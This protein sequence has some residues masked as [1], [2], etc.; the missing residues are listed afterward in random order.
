[1]KISG[2]TAQFRSSSNEQRHEFTMGANVQKIFSVLTNMYSDAPLAVFREYFCNAIDANRMQENQSGVKPRPVE[3]TIPGDGRSDLVIRDY[4]VGMDEAFVTKVFNS[5][6]TSEKDNS[7]DNIGGFGI[8]SKSALAYTSSF[9]VTTYS[10]TEVSVYSVYQEDGNQPVLQKLFS[11]DSNEPRGVSISVPVK[12]GDHHSFISAA[13][14][15]LRWFDRGSDYELKGYNLGSSSFDKPECAYTDDDCYIVDSHVNDLN[16]GPHI[17]CGSVLYSATSLDLTGISSLA[18][19]YFLQKANTTWN[20]G[21]VLSRLIIV[22]PIGAVTIAPS[23]ETIIND[24]E[25]TANFVEVIDRVAERLS[26]EIVLALPK[27]DSLYGDD[28]YAKASELKRLYS[29]NTTFFDATV[30]KALPSMSTSAVLCYYKVLDVLSFSGSA[31]LGNRPSDLDE[32]DVAFNQ[33]VNE[34]TEVCHMPGEVPSK[35]YTGFTHPFRLYEGVAADT[36]VY[37]NTDGVRHYQKALAWYQKCHTTKSVVGFS[38][39]KAAKAKASLKSIYA[40]CYTDVP[41]GRVVDLLPWLEK[42]PIPKEVKTH[43][44]DT[45]DYIDVNGVLRHSRSLSDIT[46]SSTSPMRYLLTNR[47]DVV[48]ENKESICC[49]DFRRLL[50]QMDITD[51]VIVPVSKKSVV[52]DDWV[53][54]LDLVEKGAQKYVDELG[55]RANEDNISA[56]MPVYNSVSHLKDQK[57]FLGLLKLAGIKEAESACRATDIVLSRIKQTDPEIQIARTSPPHYAKLLVRAGFIKERDIKSRTHPLI[58]L[59][60][61]RDRTMARVANV[62][63]TF[64]EDIRYGTQR[65]LTNAHLRRMF[66]DTKAATIRRKLPQRDRMRLITTTTTTTT[67]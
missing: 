52:G 26:E 47:G 9:T 53:S 33:K 17:L 39:N 40:D 42:N 45:F 36:R 10:G 64:Y 18:R 44:N 59:L 11:K 24:E 4:G 21:T 56:I 12:V 67:S 35:S 27:D 65:S 37:V 58:A 7:D 51:Y 54:V 25:T 16:Q 8:G 38:E 55:W 3:V 41:S 6:G 32:K 62:Y 20:S 30:K 50:N 43:S 48:F 60:N 1:M 28:L 66:G 13:R 49:S 61:Y 31:R 19:S 29:N 57:V 14:K 2:D 22:L 63:P 15:V 34:F 5:Y 23:R 46:G